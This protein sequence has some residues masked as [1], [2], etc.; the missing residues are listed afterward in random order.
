MQVP[1]SVVC[2]F[3]WNSCFIKSRHW[4]EPPPL[5]FLPDRKSMMTGTGSTSDDGFREREST[6][7][8]SAASCVNGFSGQGTLLCLRISIF[9][10]LISVF[11]TW[12]PKIPGHNFSDYHHPDNSAL[13]LFITR[14]FSS[15]R[16]AANSSHPR[17]KSLRERKSPSCSCSGFPSKFGNVLTTSDYATDSAWDGWSAAAHRR[18]RRWSPKQ[19]PTGSMLFPKKTYFLWFIGNYWEL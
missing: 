17:L 2:W 8:K 10:H 15:N 7:S 11:W 12:V 3:Y 14:H 18:Q 5:L 1:A 4:E 6:C 19:H 13:F 9:S 16:N